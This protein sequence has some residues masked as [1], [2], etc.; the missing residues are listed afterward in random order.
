[1]ATCAV[2]KERSLE[3]AACAVEKERNREVAACGGRPVSDT[4]EILGVC[5]E[6]TPNED[7][8]PEGTSDYGGR[9]RSE[10]GHILGRMWP[11]QLTKTTSKDYSQVKNF[12]LEEDTELKT[13]YVN[14][15]DGQ[16]EREYV[17]ATGENKRIRPVRDHM[18]IPSAVGKDSPSLF[19]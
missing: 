19:W 6:D 11:I 17:S 15:D 8:G 3:T 7:C 5:E 4:D 2:E 14:L 1:M 18:I 12:K 9:K 16:I 13:S 10:A